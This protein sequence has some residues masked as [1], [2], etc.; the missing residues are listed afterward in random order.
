MH[1]Y[2]VELLMYQLGISRPTKKVD[3]PIEVQKALDATGYCPSIPADDT[4]ISMLPGMI[5]LSK[6]AWLRNISVEASFRSDVEDGMLVTPISNSV[7]DLY[8]DSIFQSRDVTWIPFNSVKTENSSSFYG[9][10]YKYS[11][12]VVFGPLVFHRNFAFSTGTFLYAGETGQI[13][14]TGDTLIGICAA[15]GY[16]LIGVDI[17]S[18]ILIN[19]LT[20]KIKSLESNIAS[21]ETRITALESN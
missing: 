7:S 21:L 4:P 9:I 17:T 2:L 10:A 5:R 6:E 18:K 8:S 13:V 11:R 19:T 12:R 1:D 3:R 20:N 14:S 16:I 15:P